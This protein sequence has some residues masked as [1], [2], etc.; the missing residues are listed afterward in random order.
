VR[1]ATIVPGGGGIEV[2]SSMALRRS[3]ATPA[4]LTIV[5]LNPTVARQAAPAREWR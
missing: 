2:M 1:L 3:V 5:A 4:L